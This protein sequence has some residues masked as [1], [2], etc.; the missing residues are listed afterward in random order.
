LNGRARNDPGGPEY[1]CAGFLPPVWGNPGRIAQPLEEGAHSAVDVPR[2]V[3]E[4]LRV[5]AYPKFNLSDDEIQYLLYAESR[6][7]LQPT[8]SP[9]WPHSS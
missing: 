2:Q 5:L 4:F 6:S 3:D 8:Y 9:A 7:F 1:E